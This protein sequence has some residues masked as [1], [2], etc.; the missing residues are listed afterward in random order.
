MLCPQIRVEKTP[1]EN[2][3]NNDVTAG[4][5][6]TF[7]ITVFNDGAGTAN[8][9]NLFDD[10][11]GLGWSVVAGASTT[12]TNCAVSSALVN[13]DADPELEDVGQWLGCGPDT[14]GAGLSKK[15][16]VTKTT[17]NPT[18]CGEIDNT[19]TVTASNGAGDSDSGN[20]DVLCPQIRVEKTPDEIEGQAG[21]NDVTVGGAATFTITV[22]NDGDGTAN[23]VNLFDDLPGLGWSVV[24]GASTTLTNCAVSSAL[25]N[26]DADPELED[27]GQWLGC[28]P[29]TIGAGLSKKATVT[30]TTVN[31][32]DC[33]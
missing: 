16:T 11:P 15:A 22:F 26:V 18:D 21:A 7:T 2:G 20:I 1:D 23:G 14:I 5:A 9:V 25:V 29:D 6:A 30:K 13:V 3:A 12:L 8:G 4:D 19:A 32:T 33:G 28:G 27:V 10:L 17:V 24:A 31:P